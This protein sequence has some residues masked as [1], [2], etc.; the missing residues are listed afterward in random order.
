M[1]RFSVET[2][3]KNISTGMPGNNFDPNM[4]Q[5]NW[6]TQF[7]KETI[8]IERNGIIVQNKPIIT[9]DSIEIV[10][11]AL[12]GIR[13]MRMKGYRVVIFFNE[14]LITQNKIT[15]QVVDES[16]QRLM[17]IFG[18]AGIMTI[19]G[20]LYATSNLKNDIFALPNNGML[21]K[22]ENEMKVSFKGGYFA[23]DKI[24]DLKAGASVNATPVLIKT[25]EYSSTLEKLDTFANRDLK[26]K[27]KIFDT[28]LDFAN[29]LQ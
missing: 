18:Q 13:L 1:G 14:P 4:P 7:L 8:G 22:A 24:H 9:A 2:S 26:Q 16:N 3:I 27:T 10:P 20:L 11:G 17:Q 28:L 6:P 29:S 19:D 5:V 12:E 21:K 25:G 15:Q 23:G